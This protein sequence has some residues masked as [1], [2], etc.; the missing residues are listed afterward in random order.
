MI[1]IT[2]DVHYPIDAA[3]L[4]KLSKECGLSCSDLLIVCGDLGVVWGSAEDTRKNIARLL[5]YPFN[6]AFIDGNHEN[7]NLLS[8]FPCKKVFGA[9]CHVL[10]PKLV[11]LMRGQVYTIEGRTFFTMG[12]AHSV[13]KSTRLIGVDWFPD[14]VPSRQELQRGFD[15]LDRHGNQVD[16]ILTHDAP[17]FASKEL[18][19]KNSLISHDLNQ[20]L[21]IIADTVQRRAWFCGHHHADMLIAPDIHMLFNSVLR[22]EPN[23]TLTRVL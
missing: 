14:E 1:H 22:I 5:S 8:T 21:D 20:Y 23:N 16:F 18:Y 12:G 11:H 6:I 15:S 19:A 3:K 13:D 2:G 17:L 4:D 10:S 9:R 7:Y